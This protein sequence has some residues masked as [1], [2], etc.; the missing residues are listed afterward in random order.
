[1]VAVL[2]FVTP[3]YSAAAAPTAAGRGRLAVS[4]ADPAVQFE[5]EIKVDNIVKVL[6]LQAGTAE[7][8]RAAPTEGEPVAQKSRWEQYSDEHGQVAAEP[9]AP[10]PS[11]ARKGRGKGKRRGS[12]RSVNFD[13]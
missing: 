7:Q 13:Q 9:P 1:M 10:A 4:S 12:A 5:Q 11:K 2:P 8:L 6:T 3:F